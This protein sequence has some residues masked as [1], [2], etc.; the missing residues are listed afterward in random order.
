ML[1][2]LTERLD[3]GRILV[4]GWFRS[5]RH[6]YVRNT[7]AVHFG[8]ADW[9]A[10][11]CR[12]ILAG[13]ED[14]AEGVP[15][16]SEAP[17]FKK[18]ANALTT[19]FLATQAVRF[20]AS[21]ASALL[22]A[23]QWDV[24]VVDAP[25]HRFLDPGFRPAVEWLRLDDPPGVYAADPFGFDPGDGMGARVLYERYDNATRSG[26]I[27]HAPLDRPAGAAP[28]G[29][30]ACPAGLPIDAHA[31][32]PYVLCTGNRTFC[33]PQVAGEPVRLYEWRAGSWHLGPTLVGEVVLDPTIVEWNDRWWLFA[34]RPGRDSLTKLHVWW[35]PSLT[36]P[37]TSHPLNPVKTDVRSARPAGTPFVH[38]GRLYRPAQ[39]C[40]T[41]YGAAV[42]L[43][44]VEQLDEAGFTERVVN[45][46][47]ADPSWPRP[48]GVHTL[49]AVGERTLLD[50]RSRTIS[51]H[52][53]AAELNA[54]LARLRRR[55]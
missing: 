42:A 31:S 7:D 43:C 27:W 47:R 39:D 22:F 40:T 1:Q 36:G 46:V 53:T 28:T 26:E 29:A 38:E 18:P 2:R 51:R 17:I 21:Q 35:A 6:S 33:V 12:A 54:R 34:T 14:A 49:S 25:I 44:A 32:Y 45:V 13:D 15:S 52:E 41:G 50:A 37:W 24:G 20:A 5:V 10:R 16:R 4:R 23:D 3:G 30:P 19:R 55:S 8:G 9:P 48:L 11:V